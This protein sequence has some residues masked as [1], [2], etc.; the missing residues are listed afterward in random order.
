MIRTPLLAPSLLAMLAGTPALVA[1]PHSPDRAGDAYVLVHGD[2]STM[3]GSLDE[4]AA[5]RARHASP[6]LWFRRSGRTYVISDARVIERA[7]ALFGPVRA[8]EPEQEEVSA[9]QEGLDEEEEALDREEERIDIAREDLDD[10]SDG[11]AADATEVATLDRERRR[12]EERRAELRTHQSDAER[13]ERDLDRREESLE[14]EAERS[15][16]K[17][18]DAS[19]ADGSAIPE[20]ASR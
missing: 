7:E 14:R 19:V 3:S 8:L 17:L 4:L 20:P 12:L 9:L 16:W 10:D 13:R 1:A 11:S 6:F 5:L 2:T 18:L 15:L